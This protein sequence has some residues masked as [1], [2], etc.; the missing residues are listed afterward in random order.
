M[1]PSV[2]DGNSLIIDPRGR[3]LATSGGAEGVFAA[4]LDL[5]AREPLPWVGDWRSIGPRHRMPQTY[6][7]LVRGVSA[8]AY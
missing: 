6:A 5:S 7:P 8:P 1:I 4:E 3:I 2:Y